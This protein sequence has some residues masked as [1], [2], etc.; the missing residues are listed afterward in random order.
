MNAKSTLVAHDPASTV[1]VRV[2]LDTQY[3]NVQDPKL[4]AFGLACGGASTYAELADGWASADCSAFVHDNVLPH[5]GR[6]GARQLSGASATEQLIRWLS[7]AFDSAICMRTGS[8]RVPAGFRTV[9]EIVS[10]HTMDYELLRGLPGLQES[11][12]ALPFQLRF[13]SVVQ[14]PDLAPRTPAVLT[15]LGRFFETGNTVLP[16]HHALYGALALQYS[17]RLAQLGQEGAPD[18]AAPVPEIHT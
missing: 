1:T 14:T 18:E 17:A 16:R 10:L 8:T 4:I 13:S 11:A 7:L 9:L 12:H 15:G 2:F 5:L 3:T 6:A